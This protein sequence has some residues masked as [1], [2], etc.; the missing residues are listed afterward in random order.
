MSQ[1]LQVKS[2]DFTFNSGS[3]N[4]GGG[5]T[6]PA[7]AVRQYS[8]DI[9]FYSVEWF[10]ARGTEPDLNS[11]NNNFRTIAAT[12]SAFTA[13][14]YDNSIVTWGSSTSGGKLTVNNSYS[15]DV[16]LNT[17]NVWGSKDS[18]VALTTYG[19]LVSWGN[20]TSFGGNLYFNHAKLNYMG[21]HIYQAK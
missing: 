12:D 13:I 9:N 15:A 21:F 4:G 20:N 3:F 18:F 16:S 2:I 11:N 10:G 19:N 5:P 14:R 8:F 1:K 17:L 7:G 6:D